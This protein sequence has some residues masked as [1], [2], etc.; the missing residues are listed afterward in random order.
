MASTAQEVFA[1]DV[2]DLPLAE[3]LRLASLILQDV[4]Q[5]GMAVVEQSETWSGQD[6][7]DVAAFSLD[8]ASRLY[9]EAEDAT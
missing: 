9:P 7:T 5:P 2:R 3:R 8:Y 6:E 4:T 1:R